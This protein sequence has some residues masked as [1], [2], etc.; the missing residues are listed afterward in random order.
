MWVRAQKAQGSF[1][2]EIIVLIIAEVRKARKDQTHMGVTEL[3][4]RAHMGVA[5]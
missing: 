5:R 2:Y 3:E 4:R 1:K